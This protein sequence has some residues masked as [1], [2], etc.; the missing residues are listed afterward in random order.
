V[1]C[2]RRLGWRRAPLH[3]RHNANRG[4]SG[5]NELSGPDL[6]AALESNCLDVELYA[7]IER[8]FDAAIDADA[9]FGRE[10]AAFRAL[11]AAYAP[12]G[13][14]RVRMSELGRDVIR[15]RQSSRQLPGIGT[16]S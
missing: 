16:T 9:G 1:L 5:G 15:A 4:R 2:R 7:W 8:R 13:R 12:V 6:E 14:A 10:L 3:A 11:N